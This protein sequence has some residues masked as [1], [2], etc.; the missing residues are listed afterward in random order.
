MFVSSACQ[1]APSAKRCIKT[2]RRS[3][4]LLNFSA[5]QKATSAKRCIKTPVPRQDGHVFVPSESTEH[6]K[7]HQDQNFLAVCYEVREV[8]KHRAPNGALRHRQDG[9][10][11][12]VIGGQKA[13]SAKRCIK[14]FATSA[15][16]SLS[17]PCQKAPSA[18]RC[19]K[20]RT[21]RPSE[22]PALQCQKA[23]SAKRRIKTQ[24]W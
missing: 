21:V 20:T 12:R 19:I 22:R 24:G 4:F 6:Q 3:G 11:A 7:V 14:T 13:P 18:K 16:T 8:R 15:W 1:I 9:L 2:G 5:S 23:P 17:C 10:A